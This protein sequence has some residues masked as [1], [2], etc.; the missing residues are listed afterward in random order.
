M[1]RHWRD[2]Q[3]LA[4]VAAAGG[5]AYLALAH[6]LAWVPLAAIVGSHLIAIEH[7]HAHLP[8]FRWRW[9]NG[10]L[11]QALLVLCGIPLVF[12]RVHHL[13]SHHKHNW[14]DDDW[15][16]PF[17]FRHAES[18]GRPISFEYYRWTYLPLFEFHSSVHILRSQNP[19]LVRSL[20]VSGF[21][22]I[23]ASVGLIATFGVWRWMIAMGITYVGAGVL[24]GAAN[25]L[26]HYNALGD[27]GEFSAWTFTCPVHNIVS[28]NS[29]Y[30][31]LHH[32]RPSLHWSELPDVHGADPSYCPAHLVET[33]LFPGYRGPL[34][35]RWLREHASRA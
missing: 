24:L 19:R 18:P 5:L 1:L 9:L 34:L 17:N 12:W 20:L 4:H 7:N 13:G 22:L 21:V 15:S 3:S 28:Y 8:I 31:L 35:K 32:E 25:Y 14:T 30:H 26:E 33:G 23:A 29:G 10:L 6:S 2:L 27:A 11:D 16:S